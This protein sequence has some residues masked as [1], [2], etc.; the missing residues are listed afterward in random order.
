MDKTSFKGQ[1]AEY[2]R[3]YAILNQGTTPDY[4]MPVK[5]LDGTTEYDGFAP[6]ENIRIKM[7]GGGLNY[8]HGGTSLQELV[9]PVIDYHFLR[10]DYKTYQKNKAKYDTKP[11][12]VSLLSANRKIVNMIFSLNFYQKEAVGDNREAATY[13]L[14]FVDSSGKQISDTSKIIADKISDNAQERTFR[15]SFTLKPL[16]YSNQDSYYLTIADESGLQMPIKEEFQINIA[17]AVDDFN[18]GL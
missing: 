17:F 8:V 3:R 11:V 10:N 1:D 6:R 12:T 5:F 18:F 2:G 13:L 16:K 4:L 14:Y 15:C 9:V 7:N